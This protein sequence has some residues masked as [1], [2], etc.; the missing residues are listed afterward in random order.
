MKP[1]ILIDIETL[2]TQ[3]GC[4]VLSIGAVQFDPAT[5][6]VTR[7]FYS[8]LDVSHQLQSGL[9]VDADTQRW[10]SCQT[11]EAQFAAFHET[12]GIQSLRFS[13]VLQRLANFIPQRSEVYGNSPS[14]DC[15]ILSHLY[16]V[17]GIPLPWSPFDERCFRTLK[18]LFPIPTADIPPF[19]GIKHHALHDARH[20]ARHLMTILSSSWQTQFLN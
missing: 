16:Q 5:N 1:Q 7:E 3:T 9:A 6:S 17:A 20:E 12:C 19:E 14:F 13:L 4:V 18:N 10:W 8:R 2:G 11:K 15:D